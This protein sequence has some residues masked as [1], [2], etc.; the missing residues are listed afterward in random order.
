VSL[1]APN[2][3]NK[4]DDVAEVDINP[5]L[6]RFVGD[7]HPNARANQQTADGLV[8]VIAGLNERRSL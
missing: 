3:T 6:Y 1:A 5:F 2:S 7:A 4:P 8:E